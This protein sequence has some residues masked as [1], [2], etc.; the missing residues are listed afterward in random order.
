MLD[1]IL[2]MTTPSAAKRARKETK[3]E[4]G[5]H[6]LK[7]TSELNDLTVAVVGADHSWTELAARAYYE[8]KV[9]FEKI[10]CS[11]I[12]DVLRFVAEGK[13]DRGVLVSCP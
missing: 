10:E 5:N 9:D 7:V 3:L 1:R 4:N 11:T 6:T 2:Q 13:A 8:D 12:T